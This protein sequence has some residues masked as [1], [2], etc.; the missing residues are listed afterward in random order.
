MSR[1]KTAKEEQEQREMKKMIKML[2]RTGA[3]RKRR[4][5]ETFYSD[6]R[7]V[8][9]IERGR[10]ILRCPECGRLS[11][12]PD[13]VQGRWTCPCTPDQIRFV[14]QDAL[15]DQKHLTLERG[16][17]VFAEQ[18]EP[19]L[20]YCQQLEYVTIKGYDRVPDDAFRGCRRL[21]EVWLCDD[22][23][24]IGDWA[25]AGCTALETIRLPG[26]LKRIGSHAFAGCYALKNSIC[27]TGWNRSARSPLRT[28][29]RW[30]SLPFRTV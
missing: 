7:F 27:R 25:F 3:R 2:N 22:I 23:T 26:G 30:K 15:P 13:T 6:G 17:T 14:Q 10:D 28:P 16:V 1:R 8:T 29:L 11:P 21:K 5:G 9:R 24:Q 12:V 20:E 19:I 4:R 18:E